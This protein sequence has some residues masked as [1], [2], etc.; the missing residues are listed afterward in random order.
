MLHK[1]YISETS[2]LSTAVPIMYEMFKVTITIFPYFPTTHFLL[3]LFCTT[4]SP[5]TLLFFLLP[6][7]REP[8]SG[9]LYAAPTPMPRSTEMQGSQQLY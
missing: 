7:G 5:Q 3:P 6:K 4:F 1:A 8:F 9:R 2:S